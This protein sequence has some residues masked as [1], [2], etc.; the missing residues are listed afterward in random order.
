LRKLIKKIEDEGKTEESLFIRFQCWA[1]SVLDSKA[2]TNQE[3]SD[4][5]KY[6][7]DYVT[8]ID[9]GVINFTTEEAD[10]T[11]QVRSHL[12][13]MDSSA[14][15]RSQETEQYQVSREDLRLAAEAL[16]S[17]NSV[18]C[19]LGGNTSALAQMRG[20]STARLNFKALTDQESD[21]RRAADLGDKF[22]SKGDALFLRRLVTAD[23]PTPDYEQ[24]KRLKEDG[25]LTEKYE[26]RTKAVCA[27]L[28][29][30]QT[31][32]ETKIEEADS[33]ETAAVAKYNSLL[34][35]QNAE[36]ERLQQA[37]ADL[38]SENSARHLSKEEA[39]AEIKKLETQ[40]STDL[41]VIS[42]T[43]K[44]LTEHRQEYDFRV[45]F[46]KQ[47]VEAL[48]KAI[49]ILNADEA[50]DLFAKTATA[51]SFIQVTQTSSHEKAV[52]TLL[53]LSHK[54]KDK[55]VSALV[56]LASQ[57]THA[58][59]DTVVAAIDTLISELKAEGESD[60][61]EKE[62][63]E[64]KRL[65]LTRT[66]ATT[67]RQVDQG[68]QEAWT[69]SEEIEHLK[70]Q[71]EL[72]QEAIEK[73]Q[74]QLSQMTSI[75]SEENTLYQKSHAETLQ[76]KTL[77]A[78]AKAVIESFYSSHEAVLVQQPMLAGGALPPPPPP[79]WSDAYAGKVQEST[80]VVAILN[81]LEADFSQD[82]STMEASEHQAQQEY[83]TEKAALET[84]ISSYT[85][86]VDARDN[87]IASAE[88]V[89]ADLKASKET[90]LADIAVRKDLLKASATHCM[91]ITVHF[92]VRRE[93]RAMELEGLNNAKTILLG[94]NIPTKFLQRSQT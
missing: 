82:L 74:S 67:A 54:T 49:G 89:A 31:T 5:I 4:R 2:A 42:D 86:N 30:L 38:T 20:T 14:A 87:D 66:I 73:T 19:G 90:M 80:G 39:T 63:C 1:R 23:V 78:E 61:T 24:L 69:K 18:V 85:E 72:L 79:T 21:L 46:R 70:G 65:S 76:A 94:G 32:F 25:R 43:N 60:L 36:K 77:T 56:V 22:L 40:V 29:E 35:A 55:R 83:E 59:I 34:E 64:T 11:E 15:F 93:A 44:T 47:E 17:A 52:S 9:G 62:D 45:E 50:R 6:L 3:A 51:S 41:V 26:S 28:G 33:A 8:D 13:D 58:E 37:L 81:M 75:R 71:I 10:L 92:Q 53:E 84:A 88:Q 16:S 68:T 91:Y 7:Q 27:T 48:S 12:A 57:S